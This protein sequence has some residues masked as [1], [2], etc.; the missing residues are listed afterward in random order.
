MVVIRKDKGGPSV[1][2]RNI[3][4]V[5]SGTGEVYEKFCSEKGGTENIWGDDGGVQ[6]KM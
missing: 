1:R 6:I 2:A 3:T 4:V 5:V